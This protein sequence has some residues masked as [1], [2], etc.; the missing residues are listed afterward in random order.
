MRSEGKRIGYVLRQGAILAMLAV[1]PLRG[2]MAQ[3][4]NASAHPVCPLS[5]DL[6]AGPR[7]AG[8]V[9]G[10]IDDPAT[11]GRWLLFRDAVHFP[12]PGW[13]VWIANSNHACEAEPPEYG[14]RAKEQSRM[15]SSQFVIHSGDLLLLEQHTAVLDAKLEATALEPAILGEVLKVRLK[16][17]GKVVLAV[18]TGTGRANLAPADEAKR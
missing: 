12:G 3:R 9:L 7:A 8:Q 4:V 16:V 18:A 17:T 11:G 10:E 1:Y 2:Q 6:S 5:S 15:R 13:L 14:Q